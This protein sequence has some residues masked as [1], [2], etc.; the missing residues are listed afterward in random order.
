[1]GIG[2]WGLGIGD[3][4]Q[5]PIPNPQSPI[6]NPHFYY[7]FKL[8]KEKNIN[9]IIIKKIFKILKQY[10]NKNGKSSKNN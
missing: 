3:W 10:I 4:A 9:L 7:I 2:D 6:P 5:S 8:N 1:L